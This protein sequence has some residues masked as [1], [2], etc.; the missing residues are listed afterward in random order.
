MRAFLC[1]R[2]NQLCKRGTWYL[3]DDVGAPLY[4]ARLENFRTDAGH[5]GTKIVQTSLVGIPFSNLAPYII[6]PGFRIPKRV[7]HQMG[8]QAMALHKAEMK[9][10]EDFQRATE[11]VYEDER[12]ARERAQS[13]TVRERGGVIHGARDCSDPGPR[14]DDPTN[15]SGDSGREGPGDS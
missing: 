2:D 10:Q 4:K 8:E 13:P 11:D 5:M 15:D 12:K 6:E 14:K 7:L 1:L 3:G 9:E